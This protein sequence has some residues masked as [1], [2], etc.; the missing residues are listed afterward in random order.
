VVKGWQHLP[1]DEVVRLTQEA[2]RLPD[3]PTAELVIAV[4][5]GRVRGDVVALDERGRPV[6]R[7]RVRLRPKRV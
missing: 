7:E 2:L 4:E 6:A 5:Q 1:H 3:R